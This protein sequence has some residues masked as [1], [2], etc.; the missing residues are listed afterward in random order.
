MNPFSDTFTYLLQPKWPIYLLWLLLLGA[1]V[2]VVYNLMVDNGQ[3]NVKDIWMCI[4]RILLGNMW[5]QQTLWK[6]PPY[7][8][9]LPSVPNSGLKHWM[10]EL[11][12]SAA[13][14]IQ[15]ALVKNIVLPHFTIFAPM[16]YGME[17]F[18]GATLILGLFLRL[19]ATLGAL[20][21]INLWLG[22]YRAPT[23]WPWTYFFLVLLQITFAVLQAGRSL[24]CDAIIARRLGESKGVMGRVLGLIT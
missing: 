13:F 11:V 12:H 19:G 15:S 17:V 2:A 24:G 8:T 9:D 7:Y 3:R 20:M 16:V 10:I 21:A 18:I 6:L 1:A 4:A 23:E 14:A 5:W 22:L